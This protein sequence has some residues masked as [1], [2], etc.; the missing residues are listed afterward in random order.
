MKWISALRC[1]TAIVCYLLGCLSVPGQWGLRSAGPSS[2][3]S[4]GSMGRQQRALTRAVVLALCIGIA[5]SSSPLSIVSLTALNTAALDSYAAGDSIEVTFSAATNKA[6]GSD[7]LPGRS[8]VD[9]IVTFSQSLGSSYTGFWL[10]PSVLLVTII[11]SSTAAP[12][13]IGVCTATINGHLLGASVSSSPSPALNGSFA[14]APAISSVLCVAA[15]GQASYAAG[16]TIQIAFDRAT[17]MAGG[18]TTLTKSQTDALITA[19]QS[20]G[21]SYTSTWTSASVLQIVIVDPTGAA[22]PT[23]GALTITVVGAIRNAARTSAL[24]TGSVSPTAAGSF[25]A[26]L[27]PIITSITPTNGSMAGSTTITISGMLLG[28][29]ASDLGNVTVIGGVCGSAPCANV[30][31]ISSTQVKCRPPATT[32]SGAVNVQV[33]TLSG[34][35]SSISNASSRFTYNAQPVVTRVAPASVPVAGGT[36]I[37]ILGTNLA[38]SSADIGSV[39]VGGSS[40]LSPVFVNSTTI[41]CT[42]PALPSG[43]AVPVVVTSAL[44]GISSQTS[45]LV[46]LCGVGQYQRG[47]SCV[48]CAPGWY[49]T[50]AG[51]Q[52]CTASPPGYMTPSTSSAPVVCP[53]GTF[54][55]GLAATCTVCPAGTFSSSSGS[56][57]CTA[58]PSGSV[59]VDASRLEGRPQTAF[60]QVVLS[61]EFIGAC[62]VLAWEVFQ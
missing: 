40:C 39:T 15:P 1:T 13:Q 45:V 43:G 32:A 33:Q 30:V 3:R 41:R 7:A 59:C 29:S 23:P 52:N 42:V 36:L 61:N 55:L 56:A 12:P 18:P 37:T 57:A 22:P 17:D 58:C 62:A 21:A 28:T 2:R 16:S 5:W 10:S 4:A 46:G 34:G 38:Q 25:R 19:S 6:N 9:A 11:N 20:L 60:A 48:A 26:N 47:T 50:T 54:S 27:V 49:S 51:A 53:A 31:W 24:A 8:L 44:N 14:A 35:R